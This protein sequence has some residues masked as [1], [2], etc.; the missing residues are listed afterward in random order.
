MPS[1]DKTLILCPIKGT[2]VYKWVC[3]EGCTYTRERCEM[4]PVDRPEKR[5]GGR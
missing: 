2:M 3:L 1:K 5:K 4:A